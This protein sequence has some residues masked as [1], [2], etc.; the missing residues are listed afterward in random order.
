MAP[1]INDNAHSCCNSDG[2]RR[3]VE[4]EIRIVLIALGRRNLGR[5][6]CCLRLAEVVRGL[7]QRNSYL[8]RRQ[9]VDTGRSY[10]LSIRAGK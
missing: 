10:G 7:S 3:F 8:C 5:F 2:N 4:L 9:P 1:E 6:W